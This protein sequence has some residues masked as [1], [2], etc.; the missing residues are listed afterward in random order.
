MS[1]I[2]TAPGK[3]DGDA[4]ASRVP[5]QPGRGGDADAPGRSRLRAGRGLGAALPGPRDRPVG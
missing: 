4:F 1:Q 5:E 2:L 3:P